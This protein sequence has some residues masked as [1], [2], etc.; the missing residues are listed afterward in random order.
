MSFAKSTVKPSLSKRPGTSGSSKLTKNTSSFHAA[1]TKST[2]F[3]DYSYSQSNRSR[4]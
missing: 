1:S 4:I 3:L 2:P